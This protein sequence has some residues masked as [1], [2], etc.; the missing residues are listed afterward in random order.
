MSA[1]EDRNLPENSQANLDKKLDHAAKETFPSSDPVSVT[2]T[3]K[4]PDPAS[5]AGAQSPARG[6]GRGGAASTPS[7][8]EPVVEQV[9]EA[10]QA[11]YAKAETAVRSTAETTAEMARETYDQG[12]AYARRVAERYPA[13]ERYFKT[14]R[15]QASESP[16]LVFLAGAAK[17]TSSDNRVPDYARTRTRYA[18]DR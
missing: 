8:T 4:A 3:K 13:A 6:G 5:L 10:A 18:A 12:R 15:D 14:V 2:V 9:S 7:S 1:A 17:S 11:A 16:V